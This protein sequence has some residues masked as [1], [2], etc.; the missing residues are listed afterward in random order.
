M[1]RDYG[2]DGR[3]IQSY[4]QAYVYNNRDIDVYFDNEQSGYGY[5]IELETRSAR[6][7]G[8]QTGWEES[9]H[10]W[11]RYIETD[12]FQSGAGFG[13]SRTNADFQ[14]NLVHNAF[15]RVRCC[16]NETIRRKYC[17]R[18]TV[19]Q[20]PALEQGCGRQPLNACIFCSIRIWCMFWESK[21]TGESNLFTTSGLSKRKCLRSAD[22]RLS[23]PDVLADI[24]AKFVGFQILFVFM[25]PHS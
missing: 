2:T 12:H 17:K 18:D 23:N 25:P 11:Y 9:I 24:D 15:R 21:C 16:R 6:N 10:T 3:E 14:W 1:N 8:R 13:I 5:W 4:G 20:R 22:W 19:N 7:T